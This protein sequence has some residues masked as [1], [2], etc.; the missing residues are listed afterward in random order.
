MP[1]DRVQRMA[2]RLVGHIPGFGQVSGY[3]RDVLHWLPYPQGIVYR[4]SALVRRCIEG[5]APAYLRELCCSSVL[6]HC[7]LLSRWS[8]WSPERGLLSDSAEPS[9]WLVRRL[10]MISRLRC[11]LRQWRTLLY[12]SLALR[13]HRLTE[14]GLGALLSRLPRR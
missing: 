3:M 14:V 4:I 10:G 13:P 5:L 9:L 8:Y 12:F 7:A 2:T 11:V 1:I 6:S